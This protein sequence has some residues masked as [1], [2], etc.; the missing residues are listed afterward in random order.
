MNKLYRLPFLKYLKMSTPP[1]Y[2][3]LTA[4]ASIEDMEKRAVEILPKHAV[5]Y[6]GGS[7]EEQTL[8]R[9]RQAFKR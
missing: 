5:G 2:P 9:N 4:L 7:A 1:Q 8:A 6:W 3:P